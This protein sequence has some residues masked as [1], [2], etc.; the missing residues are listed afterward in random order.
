[1]ARR[2]TCSRLLDL[3]RDDPRLRTLPL[4]VRGLWILLADAMARPGFDGVLP[5][6]D[7]RRVSLLVSEAQTEVETYLETLI[8]E[9]LILREGDTLVCPLLR[10]ATT[11]SAVARA[12]G[13]KGGRPRK[14]E[15]AEDANRRRQREML[16]PV[17]GGKPSETQR[18]EAASAGATTTNSSTQLQKSDSVAR[19]AAGEWVQLARDVIAEGRLTYPRLAF[20]PAREWIEAGAELGKSSAE[21]RA[22][23]LGVVRRI[24]AKS[25]TPPITGLGYFSDAI[26]RVL[27]GEEELNDPAAQSPAEDFAPTEFG[28]E[29]DDWVAN[30]CRGPSPVRRVA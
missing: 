14:G 7:P 12:N 29:V 15:D 23:A 13:S 9:G 21:V 26:K 10:E 5:Y 16:L 8:T 30:G 2:C 27:K 1:M 6:S 11:R 22:V 28:R 25:G 3:V 4:A 24:M 18:W 20:T 19:E 17:G